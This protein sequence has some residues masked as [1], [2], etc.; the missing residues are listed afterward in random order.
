MHVNKTVAAATCSEPE[1][2][3]IEKLNLSNGVLNINT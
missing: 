3:W 1:M 2:N